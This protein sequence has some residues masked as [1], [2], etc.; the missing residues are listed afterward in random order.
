MIGLPTS[1]SHNSWSYEY[2]MR[3]IRSSSTHQPNWV[4]ARARTFW[5]TSSATSE[6]ALP[7][8]ANGRVTAAAA[9]MSDL[10]TTSPTSSRR[11]GSPLV[12]RLASV[13]V[14]HAGRFGDLVRRTCTDEARLC[15]SA[16]TGQKRSHIA[17]FALGGQGRGQE[18]GD[19]NA[20]DHQ[21]AYKKQH[22]PEDQK[23]RDDTV[24]EH[25][26]AKQGMSGA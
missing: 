14:S 22:Q 5:K 19:E 18:A 12:L 23:D 9:S 11:E 17:P 3:E 24:I 7:G 13:R 1:A 2:A 20:R 16:C 8:I 10:E 26:I 21:R 6:S 4:V 25:D 15:C